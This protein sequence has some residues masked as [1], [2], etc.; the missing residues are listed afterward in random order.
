MRA[1]I[2]N[3][4]LYTEMSTLFKYLNNNNNIIFRQNACDFFLLLGPHNFLY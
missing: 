1:H 4:V 2:D 3:S